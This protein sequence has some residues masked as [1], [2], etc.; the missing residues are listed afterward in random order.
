MRQWRWWGCLALTCGILIIGSGTQTLAEESTE[1]ATVGSLDGKVFVGEIGSKGKEKGDPDELLFTDGAFRST[2]CDP[3]GFGEAP[4]MTAIEGDAVTFEAETLSPTD[5]R[6]AWKGT[7]HGDALE[8]IATW[9]K[10]K[11]TAPE[12]LW[13]KGSLKQ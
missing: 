10:P 3:Y 1:A 5:G 8:G 7:V 12:E 13:F 11:K 9:Y 4:Y 6:I 2:A